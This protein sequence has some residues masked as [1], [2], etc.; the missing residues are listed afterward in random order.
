MSTNT[1]NNQNVQDETN[2][3]SIYQDIFNIH[4]YPTATK[5]TYYSSIKSTVIIEQHAVD[6][7][8]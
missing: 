3:I 1:N 4:Q 8:P 5:D 6:S 2:I 7:D